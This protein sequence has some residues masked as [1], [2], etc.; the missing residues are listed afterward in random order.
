MVHCYNCAE[1]VKKGLD[2]GH[3]EFHDKEI[4]SDMLSKPAEEHCEEAKHDDIVG[5]ALDVYA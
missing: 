1:F 4:T 3:C 2:H 5:R